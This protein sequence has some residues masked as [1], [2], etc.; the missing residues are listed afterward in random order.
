MELLKHIGFGLAM[1]LVLLLTATVVT[2]MVFG[3]F[4]VAGAYGVLAG[5][6]WGGVLFATFFGVLSRVTEGDIRYA[7]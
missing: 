6:V 3:S 5:V 2:V 1:G 7:R 4:L